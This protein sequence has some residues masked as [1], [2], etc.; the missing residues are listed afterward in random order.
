VRSPAPSGTAP[1]SLW[2]DEA[3]A[4]PEAEVPRLEGTERADVCIVGGGYTG[5]WTALAIKEHEPSL[6]VAIV[7]ADVCGGGA[8][9]RNGGFVLTW[10]SKLHTLAEMADRDEAVWLARSSGEAVTEMHAFCEA[11]GIDAHLRMDGWLFAATNRAQVGTLGEMVE[12]AERLGEHPFRTLTPQET[13]ARAGT[14]RVL[15]GVLEPVSATVQPALLA[16]G[17][18]RVALERGIRIFERSAMTGLDRGPGGTPV[19]RSASGSVAAGRVVLAMNAWAIRFAEIRRR[20]LVISSDVAATQP[21]PDRLAEIGWT[22]GLAISDN[23]LLVHY[24]RTTLDGRIA[25]GKGG[26]KLAFGPSVGKRFEGRSHRDAEI[27]W[28]FRHLYPSL[29]E[30][31]MDRSWTGP[32]DRSRT[33]LPFFR[34]LGGRPDI[35]YG[36]GYSGNG[37]GPAYVGGKILASLALGLQDR[38]ASCCLTRFPKERWPPEPIRFVGGT[39][40]RQAIAATE[41]SEDLDRK[42]NPVWTTLIKLSPPGMIPMVDRG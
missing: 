8:S 36:V 6:D 18:R 34:D 14:D 22:D 39:M 21:A 10:W 42:P 2:L 4:R 29:N 23:R 17:L 16:R 1:R 27:E 13:A 3:L 37:V 32:I 7:E 9:G 40:M 41:R 38:W 24:F 35:V 30:V 28:Q 26:G 5:L 31:R 15:E 25:F 33:G 12:D 19:V 11:N 20:I